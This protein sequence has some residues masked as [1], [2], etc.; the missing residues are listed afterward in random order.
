M[1]YS[2]NV[3]LAIAPFLLGVHAQVD[4]DMDD[5]PNSCK[6]ICKPIGELSDK[7]DVDLRSD[8]DADEHHLQNQCICTNQ[9]FDVAK[10]AAMCADCMH[11]SQQNNNG[12]ND[13]DNDDDDDDD[14][15][16]NDGDDHA[17]SDDLEGKW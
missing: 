12:D 5:V 4:L 16:D 17:D 10:I 14:N 8:N 2:R 7:C 1:H 11:Q 15:D 3:V 6:A 9:S 13:N